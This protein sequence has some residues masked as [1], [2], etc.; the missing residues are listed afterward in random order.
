[1]FIET[2]TYPAAFF[3]GLLSFFSPCILPIIPSYFTFIT[4]F[5]IEELTTDCNAE[6]R[7]KVFLSTVSYVL[8]FS[9]VFVLMGASASLFGNIIYKYSN[10]IRITGGILIIIFGMHLIG[11]IRIRQLYHDKRIHIVKKP[12][13]FLGPFLIGMAFAAG[14]SPCIGPLLGS[15]LVLASNQENVWQGVMLLVAYSAGLAMPFVLVSIFVNFMLKFI[16]KASKILNYVNI[17]AGIFLILIGL[18]LISNKMYLLTF[19]G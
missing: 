11:L 10:F 17:F 5:S 16:K 14:W 12:L 18:F 15:I 4:G 1:M 6:I 9:F 13:H 19:F 2:I 3:A 7:R 8:G